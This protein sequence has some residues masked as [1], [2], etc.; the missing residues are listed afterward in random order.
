MA[1]LVSDPG[2][3]PLRWTTFYT[4]DSINLHSYFPATRSMHQTRLPGNSPYVTMVGPDVIYDFT[5]GYVLLE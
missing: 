2:E 5:A 1:F 4:A 3:E